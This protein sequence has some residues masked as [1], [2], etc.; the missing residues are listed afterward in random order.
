M[1]SILEDASENLK[2]LWAKRDRALEYEKKNNLVPRT[3]DLFIKAQRELDDYL[4]PA[5][6]K[7]QRKKPKKKPFNPENEW[8]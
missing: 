7:A 8:W 1:R 5:P 2:I 6:K 4:I 3:S